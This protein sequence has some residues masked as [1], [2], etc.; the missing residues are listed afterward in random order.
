MTNCPDCGAPNEAGRKF[1][2]DCGVRLAVACPSCGT[3][4]APGSRFCGECG[5]PLAG[6][7][8]PVRAGAGPGDGYRAIAGAFVPE[9]RHPAASVP[10]SE[11]RLV[12]VLFA[13]LVGF[14]ALSEGRDPEEVREL[15]SRYFDTAREQISARSGATQTPPA[16]DQAEASVSST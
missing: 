4:N 10:V 14:T 15:L 2:G 6:A 11:R 3:S 16:A 9:G 13:D 5:S 12:T 8:P 1:C 7:E